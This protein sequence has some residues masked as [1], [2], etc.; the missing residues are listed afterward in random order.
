MNEM[1]LP[2]DDIQ[3]AGVGRWTVVLFYNSVM[4]VWRVSRHDQPSKEM[5]IQGHLLV[6]GLQDDDLG[7]RPRSSVNLVPR[8]NFLHWVTAETSH[9]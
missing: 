3:Q 8:A 7:K 1:D 6:Y 2:K 9:K 4:P 5:C